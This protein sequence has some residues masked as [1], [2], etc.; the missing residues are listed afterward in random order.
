MTKRAFKSFM[1]IWSIVCTSISASYVVSIK[2]QFEK[3]ACIIR[4]LLWRL[5]RLHDARI[6]P[7]RW[8]SDRVFVLSSLWRER[9]TL[10][11]FTTQL[12]WSPAPVLPVTSALFKPVRPALSCYTLSRVFIVCLRPPRPTG[13][14]SPVLGCTVTNFPSLRGVPWFVCIFLLSEP[15]TDLCRARARADLVLV[16]FLSL[17]F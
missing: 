14:A 11:H 1:K 6:A 3:S 2:I 16:V 12:H 15:P 13:S 5:W 10:F 8:S 17:F 9:Y 4:E 7:G